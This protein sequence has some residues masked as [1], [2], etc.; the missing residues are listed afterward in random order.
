ML[1]LLQELPLSTNLL[2]RCIRIQV[3]I[4]LLRICDI[5][6][7]SRETEAIHLALHQLSSRLSIPVKTVILLDSSSAL[8]VLASNQYK[9]PESRFEGAA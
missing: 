6:K 8:Q 7:F 9:I 5:W 4:V 2:L 3:P 1:N